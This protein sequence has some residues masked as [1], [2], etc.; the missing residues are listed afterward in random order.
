MPAY[1]F[2]PKA[3]TIF[4]DR[5]K[6]FFL[7][8]QYRWILD[9]V[10]TLYPF[11]VE[12]MKIAMFSQFIKSLKPMNF[13]LRTFLKFISILRVSS[14]R[15]WFSISANRSDCVLNTINLSRYLAQV[16][17]IW[18]MLMHA[19]K[20]NALYVCVNRLVV[21]WSIPIEKKFFS[22][23]VRDWNVVFW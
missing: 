7:S 15:Q 18:I 13:Y 6:I 1:I 8:H 16:E 23:E 4:G 3:A 21:S 2:F 5:T 10:G 22:R 19:V 9:F 11:Y 12:Y 14:D 20:K 17:S